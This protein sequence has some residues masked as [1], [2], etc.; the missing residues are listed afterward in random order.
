ML[1]RVEARGLGR[2]S[3]CKMMLAWGLISLFTALA[4]FNEDAIPTTIEILVDWSACLSTTTAFWIQSSTL[5]HP[6]PFP[7]QVFLVLFGRG[8]PPGKAGGAAG[9]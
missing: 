5:Q 8:K 6:S 7:F 2:S 3:W 4:C 1:L 9:S